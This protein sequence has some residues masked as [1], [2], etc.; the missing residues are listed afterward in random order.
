MRLSLP[1]VD[2]PRPGRRCELLQSLQRP[3]E[4]AARRGLRGDRERPAAGASDQRQRH[5]DRR[6]S[7]PMPGG[8]IQNIDYWNS[9]SG[10]YFETIGARLL[11]GRF[12]NDGDGA[13]APPWSWSTRPWRRPTG[14]T[15]AR[16]AIA[17]A[18]A[19]RRAVADH[20]RRGRGYQ[21]CRRSTGPTGTELY[22]P[23][24]QAPRTLDVSWSCGPR[25]TRCAR[26]RGAQRDP[27]AWT[28]RC[29][30]RTSARWKK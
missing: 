20:R 5:D 19:D 18:P 11:E 6:A 8:P 29:R 10:K 21:E 27:R 16:S 25:A 4:R 12:L 9:V 26:E 15:R 23:F 2:L 30:F 14:R 22:F 17:C 1:S 3:P 7:C 13:D 24:A 28:A